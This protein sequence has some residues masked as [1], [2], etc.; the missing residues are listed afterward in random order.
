[1]NKTL[2]LFENY[3]N[4]I[5]K[6]WIKVPTFVQIYH[7]E[8]EVDLQLPQYLTAC[9]RHAEK[10]WIWPKHFQLIL[11]SGKFECYLFN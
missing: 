10:I 6:L 5:A 7:V 11:I 8:N 4:H 1:M 2:N 3:S 9:L